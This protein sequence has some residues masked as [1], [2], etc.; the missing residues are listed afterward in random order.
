MKSFRFNEKYL[1]QI[2]ALQQLINLGYE[3]L[4]PEQALA[5]RQGKFGNVLL[6][7]ILR[8]QLK[9][10]NRIHYRG[11]EY[12]FSEENIQSAIQKIKNVKWDGQ[13]KTNE[14]VYDL[15]T[16]G[17]AL[18]Q[19]VEGDSKSFTLRYID[20]G[21]WKNNVFDVTA[22]FSVERT[23]SDKTARPDIVLFVNGIPFAV[24][25]CKSP[26]VEVAQ[27]VSQSIRNQQDE[28]IPRLFAYVQLVMGVNKN[29]A[30]YATAGTARKFWSV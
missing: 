13:Q 22:E 23:R 6:E 30:M 1:S 16:L 20:W 29:A 12:L 4:T 24:I 26:K 21:D 25:E 19:S 2:P 7:E 3:Y 28:Y 17:T 27:A 10:I 18:E 5:E 9:A 11:Q 15:L 14:A 8:N